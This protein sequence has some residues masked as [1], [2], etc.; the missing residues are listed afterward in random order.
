MVRRRINEGEATD[1]DELDRKAYDVWVSIFQKS[2]FNKLGFS[3]SLC[4]SF[5]RG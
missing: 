4:S 1:D 3:L 2:C 5:Y